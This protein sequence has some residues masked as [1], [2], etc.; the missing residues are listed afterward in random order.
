VTTHRS[1]PA[2]PESQ[3]LP[4]QV[5]A[6]LVALFLAGFASV[7]QVTILGKQVYDMTGRAF[8][9]GMLGFAEFIPVFLLAPV[10]GSVADSFDR[11]T[12]YAIGLFGEAA[13]S[14][15]LFLYVARG[16]TAL[17]PIFV[18]VLCFGVARAF[19]APA[20]RA[21]PIDISPPHL[22]ERVV[23]LRSL[24]FQAGIISGPIAFGFVFLLGPQYPYL[25]AIGGFAAAAGTLS[26]VGRSPVQRLLR[27]T[28]YRRAFRD[29]TDGLRFIRRQPVVAGAITL[30][31][32]AVLLGGAVALLPAIAEER[33][34]VGAVG[35][36]WLRAM[37]GVGAGA[38]AVVLSV[39]PVR[40]R[41]GPVLLGCVAL[42]G[43]ATIVF[44][45]TTSFIVAC[46]SL[47]VLAAADSVSMFIRATLVPLATPEAMRGRV[48]AV[49]NVFIG[50]SNEL[51]AVESG[52]AGQWIGVVPAVVAGG[53]GTIAVV[54]FFWLF[55]PALRNVD[56]FAEV[57]VGTEPARPVP[58]GSLRP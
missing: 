32:F 14:L 47:F 57:R 40:Q 39:R 43:V 31:L 33:L 44:G 28:G 34:G 12:V 51:G 5:I 54:I 49:E 22:V 24:A 6:L 1:E 4:G 20:S 56:R 13:S 2:E 58:D 10:A 25:A 52:L 7:G 27:G 16:P 30:D 15:G 17:W 55:V 26:L 42:F 8:D 19:V 18:L 35:L 3:R 36:G 45:L 41:V 23:A 21:L 46:G 38:T 50:A 48:L 29:A 53:V 9:L 37:I 11:R